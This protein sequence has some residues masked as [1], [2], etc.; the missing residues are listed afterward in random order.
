MHVV[1]KQEIW[2]W[3][4]RPELSHHI[5]GPE[6]HDAK[7]WIHAAYAQ[8]LTASSSRLLPFWVSSSHTRPELANVSFAHSVAK[9]NW[10]RDAWSMASMSALYNP[11]EGIPDPIIDRQL[12]AAVEDLLD[13]SG[14][15]LLWRF[16]FEA[17]CSMAGVSRQATE[18]LRKGFNSKSVKASR[19]AEIY[20]IYH[21]ISLRFIIDGRMITRIRHTPCM[22]AGLPDHIF[23]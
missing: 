12:P 7:V 11:R 5:W 17:L 8:S 15:Y 21:G 19:E 13:L 1:I 9:S 23:S 22:N 18:E 6:R 20:S 2:L 14:G 3:E 4:D 16:Q 10:Q